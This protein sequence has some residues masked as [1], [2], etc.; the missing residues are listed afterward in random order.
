MITVHRTL[1]T[2][3]RMV[4]LFI[5]PSNFA[6][7]KLL[8]AG[9]PPERVLVKSHFLDDDPGPGSGDGDYAL[10]VG[11]L[12]VDKGVRF[13]LQAWASLRNE[14]PLKIVGDGDLRDEVVAAA[15]TEGI[16]WLGQRPLDEVLELMGRAKMLVLPSLVYETFG[17]TIMEAY[18]R[19][20]PVLGSG[21]GAIAEGIDEGVTGCLF[22]PGDANDLVARARALNG[23]SLDEM[24]GAA[25]AEFERKY[26]APSAYEALM[27]CY[28]RALDR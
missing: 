23:R 8:Q 7:S 28:A 13:L 22:E 17:R 11:R 18:A 10:Y 16:D 27:N 14:I 5:T 9:L 2:W 12:S 15:Q 6:R 20:T 19:G 4:D 26:T 21:H 24:R 3:R 1:N 25:R